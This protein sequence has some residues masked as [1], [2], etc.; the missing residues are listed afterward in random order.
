MFRILWLAA[1]HL[2]TNV[3]CLSPL[4]QQDDVFFSW[5]DNPVLCAA[6]LEDGAFGYSTQAIYQGL[7]RAKDRQE[8]LILY[9]HKPGRDFSVEKIAAILQDAQSLEV[10]VLTTRDLATAAPSAGV[11]LTFDDAFVTEWQQMTEHIPQGLPLNFF[12]SRYPSLSQTKK[13]KLQDMQQEGHAIEYHGTNHENAV[14][15]VEEWGKNAFI[16]EEF[17]PGLEA[18]RADGF[19][20]T[21]YAY[22]FG[23]GTS[24]THAL[25]FDHV[26]FVRLLWFTCL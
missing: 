12:V 16:N 23:H 24:E 11:V 6:S 3:G 8:V 4:S 26:E 25:T 14:D 7:E 5:D 21:S 18:M 13:L 9:G 20:V 22:P 10:P 2:L 15:Y 19:N 1:F 17:L